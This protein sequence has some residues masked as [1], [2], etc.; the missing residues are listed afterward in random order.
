M[1]NPKNSVAN[2]GQSEKYYHK[3]IGVNSRLDAL[4]AAIL[5]VKLK[6]LNDYTLARQTVADY[7]DKAFED[8][9]FL[10]IP[11]RQ[12]QST[13]VFHQYTLIVKEGH[14]DA[15]KTFLYEHGIPTMIY[16]PLT[17]SEQEA[18]RGKGRKVGDLPT[19]K[20]LCQSVL[21][22]PIHTEMTTN[23]LDYIAETISVY[24]KE[25]S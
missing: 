20:A 11:V 17:V 13:H 1:D 6:Y 21:S 18:F 12:E 3:Y 2:H 22:L 7:Y 10:Q 23:Q 24:F 19:S 14:R 16:Y 8:I 9:D 5:D 25:N 4:Q 15:L